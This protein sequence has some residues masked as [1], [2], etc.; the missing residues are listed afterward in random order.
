MSKRT[1]VVALIGTL[2]VAAVI[3]GSVGSADALFFRVDRTMYYEGTGDVVIYPFWIAD[4]TTDTLFEIVNRLSALQYAGS[5]SPPNTPTSNRKG[6]YVLVHMTIHEEKD[7]IDVRDFNICLSP[8]DVWTGTLTLVGGVTR[9]KSRDLSN[10][11]FGSQLPNVPPDVDVPLAAAGVP[12]A[13]PIRGYIEAIM[14]DNGTSEGAGCDQQHES[15]NPDTGQPD[16]AVFDAQHQGLDNPLLGRSIL[17]NVGNGLVTGFNAEALEDYC[18]NEQD[19]PG[20]NCLGLASIKFDAAKGTTGARAFQALALAD[21]ARSVRGGY[22][23]RFIRDAANTFDTQVIVTFPTGRGQKFGFCAGDVSPFNA[24]FGT[25]NCTGKSAGQLDFSITATT[26]MALW[27]RNDEECVSI[28]PRQIPVPFEVNVITF[29]QLSDIL[30][31]T[32][33]DSPGGV[34]KNPSAPQPTTSGWFR[35]L[36]DANED[37]V[38]DFVTASSTAAA[39]TNAIPVFVPRVIPAVALE[40]IQAIA[41][42]QGRVSAS[43]PL[44]SEAPHDFYNCNN[45]SGTLECYNRDDDQP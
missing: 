13:N 8:G 4:G 25:T 39:N 31:L 3:L 14:I 17:V 36:F 45:S 34:C 20:V 2:I 32:S 7:S 12:P 37:E 38:T 23:G 28:S 27:I 22:V 30:F 21:N 40:I 33:A 5:Q 35:L 16:N 9:L 1:S 19:G 18:F 6:R 41:G 24:P 11:A 44:Q 26:T 10:N 29:T 15:T 43:F 42:A